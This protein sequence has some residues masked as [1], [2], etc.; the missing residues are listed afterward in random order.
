MRDSIRGW[1]RTGRA[2]LAG[3]LVV[4]VAWT[5]TTLAA[6]KKPPAKTKK[7]AP[8]KKAAAKSP[9]QP[10]D[11]PALEAAPAQEN[12]KARLDW[13][14]AEAKRHRE[15]V[16]TT[17]ADATRVH[18]ATIA[19]EV[20]R[21]L[22]RALANADMASAA[23]FR[24]AIIQQLHDT[25]WRLNWLAERKV[26]G[27]DFAL[28]VMSLHGILGERDLEEACRRFDS[29][30]RK[31]FL[32]AAYRHAGC[33][34]SKNPEESGS[35]LLAAADAG[36]AA[37]SEQ[38]GKRC[39]EAKP[40]D[41]SCALARL[42]ASAAAGR[43]S[44]KSLLGWLHAQG[45]GAT[46]NPQLALALY[47]EA[48]EAGDL[49]AK[50]NL[51]ELFETGRGVK[52]D[53]RRAFEHYREAAAGGFAPA[54]FNLGRLY[55]SGVGVERNVV[56]ARTWLREARKAGIPQAGQLLD[57]LDKQDGQGSPAPT[58]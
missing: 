51:G 21:D 45:I 14:L 40:P 56:S 38:L 36:H 54:Q 28:G 18:M 44:S 10:A 48:A 58:K 3:L 35:L 27:G 11:V 15:L 47:T 6:E 50:N 30:W 16:R 53:P 20:T 49:P 42:Q 2:A 43:P 12:P 46:A 9:P 55:A 26:P 7:A 39:L 5:P 52:Q 1:R 22:E 33:L 34:E 31:G 41:A 57:W 4:S 8:A 23:A 25:R 29:A 19:I 17:K 32:D 24:E 13:A 37:A